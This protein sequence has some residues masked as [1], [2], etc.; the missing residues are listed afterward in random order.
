MGV[1]LICVVFNKSSKGVR[2]FFMQGNGTCDTFWNQP[3]TNGSVG[4]R[5]L[6]HYND[7]GGRGVSDPQPQTL[8]HKSDEAEHLEICF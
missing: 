6:Q 3:E 2:P 8:H 5:E 7:T 1:V 4:K